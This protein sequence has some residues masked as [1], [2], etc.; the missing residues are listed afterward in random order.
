MF[1][2]TDGFIKVYDGV[3]YLALLGH[4]WYDKICDRVKYLIHI[5]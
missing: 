1:D 4:N 2:K 5:V 3:R